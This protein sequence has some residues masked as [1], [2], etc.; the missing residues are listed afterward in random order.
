[1][2]GIGIVGYGLAGRV[3]HANLIRRVPGLAIRAVVSTDPTRRAAATADGVPRLYDSFDALL[4]DDEVELVVV[5][6]THDTHA[7]LAVRALRAGKH[8]V[9]DKPMAVTL[10]EADA[11]VDAAAA[12]GRML[13]V[14]HNRRWDWDYLTVRRVIDEGLI[15]RPYLFET[16]VVGYRAPRGTWRDEPTTMGSLVH[17][18]GAHLVDHALL[19]VGKPVER[20]GCRILRPRPRP[21]V[22]NY[23]RIDLT[24]ADGPLYTIEVGNLGRPGKPRWYVLGDEGGIVKQGLDPQERALRATGSVDD[25]VELPEERT[26]VTTAVAGQPAEIV[27]EAVRGSWVEYYRNVWAHLNEGAPLAVTAEQAREVIRVLDA[28]V[29]SDRTGEPV[30]LA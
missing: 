21:A 11:M 24:F 17:D 5:A 23:A 1:M 28:A 8:V 2:T 7:S 22:G 26:R 13:S 3:M 14:F 16:A 25:A 27:L 30:R 18:W 4:R 19:L 9:V 12:A 29:R 6:T 10:A 20:V 15:G